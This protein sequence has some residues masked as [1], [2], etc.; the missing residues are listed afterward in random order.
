LQAGAT[1]DII[2]NIMASFIRTRAALFSLLIGLLASATPLLQA[3]PKA[4]FTY[5]DRGD[6]GTLDPNRMSWMQDIRVGSSL[7]EGLYSIDPVSFKPVL[8]TADKADTS[9]GDKTWTFHIRDAA[10]WSNG[11]K[12]VSADFAFAWKRML[13]EPGDY[14]YLIDQYVVGAKEYEDEFAKY[15]QQRGAGDAK[16]TKPD[17][18]KVGIVAQDSSTLIVKLKHPVTFF[19]DLCAFPCYYPLNEKAMNGFRELDAKTDRA[20]YNAAWATP[21]NL[22][23]NGPHKLVGWQLRRGMRLEANDYYWDAANVKSKSVEVVVADEPLTALHKYDANEVDCITEL[24]GDIAANM[25]AQGRKD[26]H[27]DPSFG[28]YFY[29]FNCSPK[30]PGGRANPFAD[31]RVRQALS[32]AVDKRPIVQ[33]VTK[34]GEPVTDR[35]IPQGV[36]PEYPSA[37]GLAFD[38]KAARKLMKDAG[39]AGGK[40]FPQIKL[41]YNTEGDHKPIAEYIARQWKDNLAIQVDL[42]GIEIKQFQQRLHNKEYDVARASW[43]GDY[44]DISTFT[45]KY[46]S[47]S[48]NN[49]ANWINPEYDDL[50]IKAAQEPNAQKRLELLSKAEAI[51]NKEVP[52][53]PLYNY[54]NKLAFR[55]NVKGLN[56]N[57]RNIIIF[58][59]I[60]V[61]R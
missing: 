17:F 28:T 31:V 41:T 21:P 35:Y 24:T 10:K 26:L 22:V 20:T 18:G 38:I 9:D 4:D 27:I 15:L 5:I 56:S 50:C 46:L 48:L 45:D 3:A 14:T 44:M 2:S 7:W 60:S 32:M 55:E 25:R 37:P 57:P 42:E 11:D 53:L 61:Q 52:I 39:Y 12:V 51:L 34:C 6:I 47:W 13:E 19:P 30:L 36:F 33:N 8:A 1:L 58:K 43:Y 49:D 29:S 16:V 59:A 54:V 40:G 23:G